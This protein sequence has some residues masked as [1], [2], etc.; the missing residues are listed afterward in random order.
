MAT[1]KMRVRPQDGETQLDR[2]ARS[3]ARLKQLE[4]QTEEE[5]KDA[6]HVLLPLMKDEQV[7]KKKVALDEDTVATISI[8]TREK[9]TIDEERLK[10]AIG[11]PAYNKLTSATLDEAKVEAAISLGELDPNVV[12]GCTS[13]T[14]TDYLEVRFGK[15]RKP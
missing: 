2:Q 1:R 8:K 14:T 15:P 9:M 5:R 12:A 4:R 7:T 11:A 3:Y 13:E 6:G 10:K